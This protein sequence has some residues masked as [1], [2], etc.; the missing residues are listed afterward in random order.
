[1]NWFRV[2]C[3]RAAYILILMYISVRLGECQW[4]YVNRE[5]FSATHPAQH[6]IH[7]DTILI[8]WIWLGLWLRIL[9][10]LTWSVSITD[11]INT[12]MNNKMAEYTVISIQKFDGAEYKS[13]SLEIE[14]LWVQKQVLGIN[15]T[16]AV[17]DAKDATEFE[18]W[19]MWH[20]IIQSTILLVMERLLQQWYSIQTDGKGILGWVEEGLEGKCEAES[21]GFA[22]A[23]VSFEVQQLWEFVETSMDDWG[24]HAGHQPLCQLRQYHLWW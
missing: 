14:I 21:E 3:S 9:A 6:N 16:E 5:T 11:S 8:W 10:T 15:S 4:V 18:P 17:P 19:K 13:W 12:C 20:G 2:W 24:V 22:R 23:D 1:M 7:M